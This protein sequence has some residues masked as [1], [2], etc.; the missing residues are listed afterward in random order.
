MQLLGAREASLPQRHANDK[1]SLQSGPS[2]FGPTLGSLRLSQSVIVER[3]DS[4]LAHS[5]RNTSPLGR[6]V[7][8]WED[9]RLGQRPTFLAGIWRDVDDGSYGDVRSGSC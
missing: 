4:P 6:I 8:S 1:L 3:I 9:P 2:D 5:S 7:G